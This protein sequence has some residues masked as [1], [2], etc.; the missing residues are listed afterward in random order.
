MTVLFNMR[1]WT[2]SPQIKTLP[3]W[4]NFVKQTTLSNWQSLPHWYSLPR[5]K[6]RANLDQ[7]LGPFNAKLIC[8][9]VEKVTV[10]FDT[11]EDLAV[12]VLAWS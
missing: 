2:Q 12:F 3:C 9:G 8:W 6:R 1:D 10:E 11:K 5:D 7:A 4:V